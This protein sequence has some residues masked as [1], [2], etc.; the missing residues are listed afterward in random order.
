MKQRFTLIILFFIVLLT[1]CS[2]K[3]YEYDSQVEDAVK[4]NIAFCDYC[5]EVINKNIQAANIFGELY[6]LAALTGGGLE[7]K[8]E[9][10]DEFD[11]SIEKEYYSIDT[12]TYK[13]T[14]EYVSTWTEYEYYY[15]FASRILDIY[16]GI[17]VSLS[18]YQL[19]K[20]S[21]D[22]KVWSFKELN[23]DLQFLFIYSKE[24]KRYKIEA[25]N[26]SLEKYIKKQ[27]NR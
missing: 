14:L 22:K 27:I 24:T 13:S 20:D 2:V 3:P 26:T 15:E 8:M 18:D 5:A 1:S 21:P 25:L 12:A 11:T 6:T 16:T 23:T 19:V 17:N 9:E 4:Y 7:G 10:L